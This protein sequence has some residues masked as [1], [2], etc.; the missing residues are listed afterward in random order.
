MAGTEIIEVIHIICNSP[1][2][3]WSYVVNQR[4][5]LFQQEVEEE[6]PKYTDP[7]KHFVTTT[8]ILYTSANLITLTLTINTVTVTNTTTS[9]FLK[10]VIVFMV[11]LPCTA[12]QSVR[13][14]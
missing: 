1:E 12:I 4:L 9:L 7:K 10:L 3:A 2:P 11:L 13:S 8:A 14:Y 6:Y 5:E